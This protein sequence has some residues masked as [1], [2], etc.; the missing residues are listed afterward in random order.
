MQYEVTIEA[1]K[2][3]QIIGMELTVFYCGHYTE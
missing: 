1:F 3:P 2:F